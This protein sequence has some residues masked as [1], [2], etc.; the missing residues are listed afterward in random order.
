MFRT[1]KHDIP[2]RVALI[3]LTMKHVREEFAIPLEM[4]MVK[5]IEIAI[6]NVIKFQFTTMGMKILSTI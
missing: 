4:R 1:Q 3:Y 5:S 2:L 6:E